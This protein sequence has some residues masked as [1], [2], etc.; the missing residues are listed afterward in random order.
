MCLLKRFLHTSWKP[1][2][3][4]LR[5]CGNGHN[6]VLTLYWLFMEN[7]TTAATPATAIATTIA[8]IFCIFSLVVTL[9][10]ENWRN[11]PCHCCHCHHHHHRHSQHL[12]EPKESKDLYNFIP[13]SGSCLYWYWRQS[14]LCE[15]LFW[16]TFVK[17]RISISLFDEIIL[18][19]LSNHF[20]FVMIS[21][22]LYLLLIIGLKWHLINFQVSFLAKTERKFIYLHR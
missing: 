20:D 10:A 19:W 15:H 13:V 16:P 11:E 22:I 3:N 2:H 8:T 1:S 5:W 17:L 18:I 14:N 7:I 6:W 12:F 21:L 4:P 9:H